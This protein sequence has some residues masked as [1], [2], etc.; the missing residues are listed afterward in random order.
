MILPL[1]KLDCARPADCE[2]TTVIKNARNFCALVSFCIVTAVVFASSQLSA[3][4]VNQAIERCRASNGK[5]AYLAC[6]QSGGTH[7]ACYDRAKSIVQSCVKNAMAAAR[8][9]AALFSVD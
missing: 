5:P 6:K 8:P 1:P 9:K 3:L 7:E 4:E 2:V